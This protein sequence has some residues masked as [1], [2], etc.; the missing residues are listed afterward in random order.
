MQIKTL[1][2]S[3]TGTLT[4]LVWDEESRDAVVI[5]PVLDFNAR[6]VSF[7]TE[8][9]QALY[10]EIESRQ[11]CVQG[12]LDTHA[13][14]DHV[15][16]MAEVQ[17]RYGCPSVVGSG[18][19]RVQEIFVPIFGLQA[20]VSSDGSQF[21]HLLDDGEVLQLG[22]LNIRALHTPGHTPACTSFLI[23]DAVFTGDALFMPDFGTGRCD[24]PDGS[25]E[26]LYDSVVGT[27]YAL[28]PETRVFV[29]HDYQPGGRELR[30]ES[31]IAECAAQNKQLR[32]DTSRD[33]FVRWRTERDLEL[34]LPAL[35]FQA[36]QINIDGGRLPAPGDGGIRH[37][38]MPIGQFCKSD[39]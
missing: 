9:L 25:A 28:P 10:T 16:G 11:L 18:F 19:R 7:S 35:L 5:D 23:G 8:A 2:H 22:S 26:L 37:L 20:M 38:R 31:T 15:S 32:S 39:G 29:G 12:V 4:Y 21:D 34:D 3:S 1:H 33:E 36:I 27:L 30:F 24:F 14:A 17:T 6:R 13:H